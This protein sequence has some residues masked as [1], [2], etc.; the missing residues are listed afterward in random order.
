MVNFSLRAAGGLVGE[1]GSSDSEDDDANEMDLKGLAET[2][3][4]F[5]SFLQVRSALGRLVFLACDGW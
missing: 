1:D 2:D 3:P 4:E 5:F